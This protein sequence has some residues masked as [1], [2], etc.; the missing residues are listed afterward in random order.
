MAIPPSLLPA[1][2]FEA[3]PA[4]ARDPKSD[5]LLAGAGKHD[6]PVSVTPRI[7][8]LPSLTSLIAIEWFLTFVY[9]IIDFC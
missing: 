1:W 4:Y 7:G 5:S 6:M 9:A 2:S 3:A 8:R